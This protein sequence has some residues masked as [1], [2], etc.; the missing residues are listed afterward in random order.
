MAKVIKR[1]MID[2][3]ADRVFSERFK[4]LEREVGSLQH[5]IELLEKQFKENQ[6]VTPVPVFEETEGK[7]LKE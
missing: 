1:S 2:Q 3:Q 7:L 6:T 4:A 5:R